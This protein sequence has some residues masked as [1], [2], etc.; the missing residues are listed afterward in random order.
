MNSLQ[1][2]RNLFVIPGVRI[3]REEFLCVLLRSRFQWSLGR[4]PKTPTL[5]NTQG[6]GARTFKGRATRPRSPYLVSRR[7][8]KLSQAAVG[9]M[10]LLNA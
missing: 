10:R 9:L 5:H 6:W 1:S 7:G 2:L 3:W 4:A 8:A